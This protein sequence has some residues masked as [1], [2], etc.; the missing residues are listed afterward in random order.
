MCIWLPHWPIQRF[1]VAQPA[2]SGRV[3]VLHARDPRRGQRVVHCDHRA[4]QQGIQV[5]MSLAEV[6]ATQRTKSGATHRGQFPHLAEHDPRADLRALTA[7][8][9]ACE[10]FSPSVGLE[11]SSTPASLLLDVTQSAARCGGESSLVGAVHQWLGTLGYV[12]SVA[13]S[14]HLGAAWAVAHFG[15]TVPGYAFRDELSERGEVANTLPSG[16]RLD[17][18]A[19][20]MVPPG[21]VLAALQ[22]LPIE[23]LRVAEATIDRLQQLGIRSVGQLLQLPRSGLQARFGDELLPRIDQAMGILP[24]TF[25]TCAVSVPLEASFAF[26]HPT[27]NR[28]VLRACL[29]TLLEQVCIRL[30]QQGRGAIGIECHLYL[31]DRT[32]VT[33][34]LGLFRPSAEQ[35]HLEELLALQF[36]QRTIKDTVQRVDLCVSISAAISFCQADLLDEATHAAPGELARFVDRV[37]SRLGQDTVLGARLLAEPQAEY[38]FRYIPLTDGSTI[39]D[40]S[41]L[42]RRRHQQSFGFRPLRVI[43]PERLHT[44]VAPRTGPPASFG[45]AGHTYRIQRYWGPERIETG[46]WRGQLIRRDYFQVEDHDGNRFWLF[47]DLQ[48]D[49]WFVQ[50]AFD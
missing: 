25:A 39:A 1:T 23:S 18:P 45:F 14:D 8:A 38:A 3:V 15:G 27:A 29:R 19:S 6:A 47:R 24:E 2:L 4:N 34:S 49:A 42:A 33:I 30:S 50:G 7:L 41:A 20:F 26:E 48:R 21:Q 36:E 44:T 37:S 28:D 43:V 9:M 40:G 10:R 46:W 17:M 5:G 22:P 16:G 35:A 11:E 31:T 32:R 12:A 13:V